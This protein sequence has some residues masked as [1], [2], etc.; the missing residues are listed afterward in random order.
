[1]GTLGDLPQAK[2]ARATVF[3]EMLSGSFNKKA[4]T[5]QDLSAPQATGQ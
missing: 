1:M 3:H 4:K 2:D 5:K